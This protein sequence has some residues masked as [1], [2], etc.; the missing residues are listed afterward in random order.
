[1]QTVEYKE[2][3]KHKRAKIFAKQIL[4]PHTRELA[5]RTG[6]QQLSVAIW[7]QKLN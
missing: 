3:Q 6:M 2:F 7:A 5:V 4:Q 1:L